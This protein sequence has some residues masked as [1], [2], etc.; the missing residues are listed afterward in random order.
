MDEQNPSKDWGSKRMIRW[1]KNLRRRSSKKYI[2]LVQHPLATKEESKPHH[3]L[4]ARKEYQLQHPIAA[5]E[6]SK[7]H[8]PLAVD[9]ESQPQHPLTADEESQSHQSLEAREESQPQHF[10]AML[11]LEIQDQILELLPVF[12]IVKIQPKGALDLQ[13]EG[14]VPEMAAIGPPSRIGTSSPIKWRF[15]LHS[16]RLERHVERHFTKARGDVVPRFRQYLAHR[17]LYLRTISTWSADIAFDVCEGF[18]IIEFCRSKMRQRGDTVH[19]RRERALVSSGLQEIVTLLR[20][21]LDIHIFAHV[22]R[23]LPPSGFLQSFLRLTEP[24]VLPT[25]H[26]SRERRTGMYHD[27]VKHGLVKK[28]RGIWNWPHGE[29]LPRYPLT[30][31]CIPGIVDETL[32]ERYEGLCSVPTLGW[33]LGCEWMERMIDPMGE[34]AFCV[35]TLY[36]WMKVDAA[37][38]SGRPLHHTYA[39]LVVSQMFVF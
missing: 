20:R 9:E 34:Y 4:A 16:T 32:R 7:P 18:A 35:E 1:L 19:R 31:L 17:G 22:E 26:L 38:K 10:L 8:H 12:D 14:A 5:D 23:T 36:A 24:P 39:A 13:P 15:N 2:K 25:L 29:G 37:L 3:P 33:I 28:R 11:P 6:E 27:I 21:L 30:P